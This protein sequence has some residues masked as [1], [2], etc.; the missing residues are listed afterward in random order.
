[1]ITF[2]NKEILFLLL[3][4]L[5]Y[6][7]WHFM[8]HHRR[9]AGITFSD[10]NAYRGISPSLKMRL[11]HTPFFLRLITLTLIILILARPQ[12]KNAWKDAQVEGIDIMLAIDASTSMLA[13]D[14]QPNRIEAAKNVATEFINSRPNDNIG[15]TVFAAEAFT[16]CPM[17]TD[18]AS[19]LS[20]LRNVSCDYAMHGLIDD[21]TAIGMGLTNAISRLRESKAKSK[22][23]ILL[24]DGSNNRGEISPLTAA[25]IAATFGIR[26][27]TIGVGTNGTAPFPY[28]LPGGGVHYIQMPCEI[29]TKTL[30][31]IA[32]ATG[33]E[34]YRAT[35]TSQLKKVYQDIDKL[36]RTKY[37]VRKYSK[38]YDLYQP[39]AMLA[40]ITMLLELLLGA[41][42]YRR[43]P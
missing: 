4:L 38:R 8:R 1:M 34:F 27:Y 11:M 39:L 33:G 3:L 24:T 19:L 42:V 21:G 7:V 36:E 5:P 17:T 10:T 43:L 40:V 18:H 35:S 14:L 2:A 13:E 30:D 22:V 29:D 32:T 16:Q 9:E 12:G 37:N 25:D 31:G 23:I 6:A 20:Q 41:T 28:P 26:I 15:L